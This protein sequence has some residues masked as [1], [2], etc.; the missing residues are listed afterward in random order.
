[1]IDSSNFGIDTIWYIYD[2]QNRLIQ[3]D[4]SNPYY[5]LHY[6]YQGN[7]V[8]EQQIINSTNAVQNERVFNLNEKGLAT[9]SYYTGSTDTIYSNF[10]TKNRLIESFREQFDYKFEYSYDNYGDLAKIIHKNYDGSNII[11]VMEPE[12][13][14]SIV[15]NPNANSDSRYIRLPWDGKFTVHAFKKY[16]NLNLSYN[17]DDNGNIKKTNEVSEDN[18]FVSAKYFEY[19]CD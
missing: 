6:K 1:M 16:A 13:Y 10:D 4:Y 14:Y 18:S 5:S 19:K 3:V 7:Q 15:L 9:K 2:D 12:Y 17:L 8:T 11:D